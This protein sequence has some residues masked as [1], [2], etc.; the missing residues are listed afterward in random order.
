MMVYACAA[1]A[2]AAAAA[3]PRVA[4]VAVTAAAVE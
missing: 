4:G 2:A 1:A 3:A